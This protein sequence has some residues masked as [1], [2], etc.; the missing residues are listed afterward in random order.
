MCFDLFQNYFIPFLQH[1]NSLV[2][3]GMFSN[4]YDSAKVS[5]LFFGEFCKH[6]VGNT[7]SLAEANLAVL[8][9][10]YP[11]FTYV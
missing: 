1:V 10:G 4:V 7:R 8:L 6:N 3:N 11:P 9:Q 5:S 2:E